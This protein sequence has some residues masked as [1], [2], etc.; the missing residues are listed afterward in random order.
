MVIADT[1]AGKVE[2]AE[3]D[4]LHVFLGIPFAARPVGTDSATVAKALLTR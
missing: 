4:G 1:T 3:Q 2:G